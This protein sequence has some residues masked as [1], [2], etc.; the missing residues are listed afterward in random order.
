MPSREGT[1]LV[2]LSG[3]KAFAMVS[4]LGKEKTRMTYSIFRLNEGIIDSDNV[5]PAM[6]NSVD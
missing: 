4:E 2:A 1:G 6:F 5:D 3:S